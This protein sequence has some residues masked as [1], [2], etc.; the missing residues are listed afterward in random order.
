MLYQPCGRVIQGM[1]VATSLRSDDSHFVL[2]VD[3][4]S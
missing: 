4:V 3:A 2:E 1:L